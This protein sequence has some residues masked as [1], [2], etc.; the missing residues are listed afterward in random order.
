MKINPEH[1]K[2]MT[3]IFI[4]KSILG[5]WLIVGIEGLPTGAFQ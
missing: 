2:Y 3:G 1:G 4:H 5:I